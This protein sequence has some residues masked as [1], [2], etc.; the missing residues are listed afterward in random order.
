MKVKVTPERAAQIEHDLER[1]A[2]RAGVGGSFT[3]RGPEGSRHVRYDVLAVHDDRFVVKIRGTRIPIRI[4][5][6]SSS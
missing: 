6:F 5:R 3:A 4:R 1:K 2:L